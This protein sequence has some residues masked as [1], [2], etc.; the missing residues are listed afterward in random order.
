VSRVKPSKTHPNADA[1]PAGVGGPVLRALATVGIKSMAQL[2]TW[3]EAEFAELHGVGPKGI[4]ILAGALTEQ[5]R[6]F[7]R[8]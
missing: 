8:D 4:R 3:S 1:F 7:R 6:H 2:A 5:G